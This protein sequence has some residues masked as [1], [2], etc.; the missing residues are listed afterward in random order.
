MK[1]A[2]LTRLHTSMTINTPVTA[3][4]ATTEQAGRRTDDVSCMSFTLYRRNRSLVVTFSNCT[5]AKHRTDDGISGHKNRLQW[6][7]RQ[8]SG[9]HRVFSEI[10]LVSTGTG[11]PVRGDQNKRA[12][13]CVYS[14]AAHSMS[15]S[16]AVTPCP[17]TL[18]TRFLP[19]SPQ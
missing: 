11:Q 15:Y 18:L 6:V 16:V 12:N 5:I 13:Q 8:L 1:T 4:P 19:M 9:R 17:H 2:Q 3:F 10:R 7:A 14:T